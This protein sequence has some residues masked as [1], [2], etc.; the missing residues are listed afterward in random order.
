MAFEA[1]ADP[2]FRPDDA[3]FMVDMA[4]VAMIQTNGSMWIV[5]SNSKL[6]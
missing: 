6:M 2:W 5:D 1:Y 3:G 4:R